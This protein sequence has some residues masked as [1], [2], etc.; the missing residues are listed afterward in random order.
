MTYL[1]LAGYGYH[2]PARVDRATHPEFSAYRDEYRKP[3]CGFSR[4]LGGCQKW[5]H[6]Y[7]S[8]GEPAIL[9]VH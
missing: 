3:W 9:Q 8:A 4:H 1:E 7:F 6:V 5:S 2:P